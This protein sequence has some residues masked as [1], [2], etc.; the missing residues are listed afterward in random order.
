[1]LRRLKP[2]GP[3]PE[4]AK[5][6]G[7][8]STLLKAVEAAGLTKYLTDEDDLTLFAP[9][10]EAFEK[11][12][13]LDEIMADKAALTTLLKNHLVLKVYKA[14]DLRNDFSLLTAGDL[15]VKVSIEGTKVMINNAKV[16]TADV[17]A[18]NGIIHVV[19]NVLTA[20]T[21]SEESV[22]ESPD[23]SSSE[24]NNPDED[25]KDG[26]DLTSPSIV[27]SLSSS[28]IIVGFVL[29]FL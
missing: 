4:V 1:L 9:T 21:D 16:I 25:S 7:S 27:K 6:N 3:I 24:E 20:Q 22:E 29:F 8:F 12:D 19:D 11:V 10:D 17:E 28:V 2:P 5:E 13:N 15:I 14:A 18:F 26:T 23:K